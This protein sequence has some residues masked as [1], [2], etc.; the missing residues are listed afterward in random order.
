MPILG[1]VPWD[2]APGGRT[3]LIV[4]CTP[5]RDTERVRTFLSKF[6]PTEFFIG[7][8]GGT[9]TPSQIQG[10]CVMLARFRDNIYIILVN[11]VAH[12]AR[13]M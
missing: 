5:R 12:M 2:S 8:L 6:H 13:V 4:Q 1:V 9:P 10:P 11:M 3:N 7:E